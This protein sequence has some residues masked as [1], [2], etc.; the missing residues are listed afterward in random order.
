MRKILPLVLLFLF[1][2][3]K[4]LPLAPNPTQAD[5]DRW[6]KFLPDD[7]ARALKIYYKNHSNIYDARLHTEKTCPILVYSP[8]YFQYKAGGLSDEHWAAFLLRFFKSK[9]EEE[10]DCICS[11]ELKEESP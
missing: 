2:C 1:S 5:I 6:A 4:G 11:E 8:S 9:H 10:D 3:G 7:Q